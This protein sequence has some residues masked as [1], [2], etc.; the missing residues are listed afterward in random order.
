MLR[1]LAHY[2]PNPWTMNGDDERFCAMVATRTTAIVMDNVAAEMKIHRKI[3]A[4]SEA[5]TGAERSPESASGRMRGRKS[6]RSLAY[7]LTANPGKGPE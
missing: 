1:K 3:G 2:C 7:N 6:T 4:L 5:Y